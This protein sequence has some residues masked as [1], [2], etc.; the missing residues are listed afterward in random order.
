MSIIEI[1]NRLITKVKQLVEDLIIPIDFSVFS[2]YE[3]LDFANQ[4]EVK[5]FLTNL[6]ERKKS[7]KKKADLI[8]DISSKISR[9]ESIIRLMDKT[10]IDYPYY[11]LHTSKDKSLKEVEEW[12]LM[13]ISKMKVLVDNP[14]FPDT[15]PKHIEEE[16]IVLEYALERVKEIQK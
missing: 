11:Y 7:V 13:L 8:S 2:T 4:Q 6:D 9:L 3:K 12:A 10:D 15:N 5:Q 16:V 1:K 14:C